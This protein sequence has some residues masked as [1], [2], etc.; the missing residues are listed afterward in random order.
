MKEFSDVLSITCVESKTKQVSILLTARR[1]TN[2]LELT[3]TDIPG[4]KRFQSLAV[5]INWSYVL[6]I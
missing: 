5:D 6:V 2:P 1:V 4:E 3:C